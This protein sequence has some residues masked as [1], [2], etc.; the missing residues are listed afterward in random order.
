M[1]IY[2]TFKLH[3]IVPINSCTI[4]TRETSCYCNGCL[5][6]PQ[7]SIHEWQEQV[8]CKRQDEEVIDTN[9]T[10]MPTLQVSAVT[11]DQEE[12]FEYERIQYYDNQPSRLVSVVYEHNL[13]FDQI[14]AIDI[15]DDEVEI[16]VFREIRKIWQ[17][18]QNA[19]LGRQIVDK[20]R[21]TSDHTRK[22]TKTCRKI[23]TIG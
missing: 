19:V 14:V 9:G 6:N 21:K 22:R 8:I 20:K 18:I 1:Q 15:D 17:S 4:L 5:V 3:A 11:S 16:I 2:V 23:Q 7:T 12:V 13:Y 10:I